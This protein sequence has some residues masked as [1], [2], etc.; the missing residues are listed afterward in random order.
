MTA[1]LDQV[2]VV[3][4]AAPPRATAPQK[5]KKKRNA[6]SIN[7]GHV[8]KRCKHDRKDWDLCG[9]PFYYY[10][11]HGGRKFRGKVPGVASMQ[12]ARTAYALIAA[13]VRNGQPPLDPQPKVDVT[14]RQL[15]EEWLKLPRDR[16]PSTIEFYGDVMRA[17]VNPVL[18]ARYFTTV[19]IEDCERLVLGLTS[20]PKKKPASMGLK[21]KVARTLHTLCKFGVRKRLR[22]DNPA[23]GLTE[24]I[25]DPDAAPENVAL[26]PQDHTKYFTA[27]E[28]Q[29]LLAT[30]RREGFPE[31]LYPFVLT[32]LSTGM[33]LGELRAL[34]YDRINW[35]GSYITVD[36]AFV[37]SQVT[38][39][40]NRKMRTVSMSRDLRATLYLRWRRHRTSD[41]V[42]ASRVGTP[43]MISRIER[44]WTK[45]LEAAELGYRTRHA[46]RHTH[47]SLLIQ[48]GVPPAKVA[49][50]AGRSLEET[51]RT[52]AHFAPG[53]NREDAE[54]LA[55]LLSGR[56]AGTH[57]SA[58]R[59]FSGFQRPRTAAKLRVVLQK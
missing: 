26:D 11:T 30:C 48:N 34:R 17:H 56:T 37:R 52:Y 22:T 27:D 6:P 19:T 35:R 59:G 43:L 15:G 33:R 55:G 44:V 41:L 13:R 2:D 8:T 57:V 24:A 23:A 58:K 45:L 7:D 16:K 31:W 12:E 18:G 47:S 20:G 10:V 46:M 49:A 29:H 53:G 51:M 36:Q 14:V 25:S 3:T 21:K 9:C 39:P 42:F 50:E 1:V 4:A 32:G 38:T 54:V 28:A 5:R 40:K